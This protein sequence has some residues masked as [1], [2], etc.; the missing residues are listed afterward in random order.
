MFQ[1]V[2][3]LVGFL[4]PYSYASFRRNQRFEKF[5]ALFP[6]AI[7][8]ALGI[9]RQETPTQPFVRL[10]SVLTTTDRSV[11]SSITGFTRYALAY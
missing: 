10:S 1:V 8:G 11:R 3:L 2:G 9:W 4:L 6:E 7:E 5:E